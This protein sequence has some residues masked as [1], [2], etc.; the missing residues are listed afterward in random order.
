[1]GGIGRTRPAKAK[2]K[3]TDEKV[4]MKAKEQETR[5]RGEKRVRMAP[6]MGTGGSHPQATSDPRERDG[7]R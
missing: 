1:M 7:G 2:E 3:G 4:S 5:E 6:N